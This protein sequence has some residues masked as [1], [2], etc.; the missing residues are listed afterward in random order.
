MAA[1]APITAADVARGV[2]RMLAQQ[3]MTLMP[4]V[5][6]PNGRRA[7]LIAV[8]VKG[9]IAIVEIKVAQA[10]LNGDAKWPDYVE[11]CDRFYWAL[12]PALNPAILSLPEYRPDR[13]GLIIA[14]RYDAAIIRDA[15]RDP[16]A[17]GRR[18]SELLRLARLAMRRSMFA[19]DPDLGADWADG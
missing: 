10:D 12:A 19:A 5:T 7:D 1:A 17:P 2:T 18:K 9:D 16:I 15:A 3:G 11:W 14:D 8:D 13:T 4:E 6:L